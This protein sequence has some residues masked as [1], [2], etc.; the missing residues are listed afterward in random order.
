MAKKLTRLG[1]QIEAYCEREGLSFV[2]FAQQIDV[3]VQAIYNWRVGE[4]TPDESCASHLAPLLGMTVPEI[5]GLSEPKSKEPPIA[6]VKTWD[7]WLKLPAE[8]KKPNTLFIEIPIYADSAAAGEGYIVRDQIEDWA[9]IP[10]GRLGKRNRE[11]LVC[12]KVRGNSMW[13][14]LHDKAIV[15]IDKG[16]IPTRLSP[17]NP[18]D[19]YAVRLDNEGIIVKHTSIEGRNLIITS[20]NADKVKKENRTRVIYIDDDINKYVIGRA[21]WVWQSL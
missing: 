14:I 3:S 6:I 9:W 5:M 1:E 7:E 21:V 11:N 4:R 17:P 20:A 13:P 18:N 19:I 10:E 16:D 12:I 8:E 2:G 15:C